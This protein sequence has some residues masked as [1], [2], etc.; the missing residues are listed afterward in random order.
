MYKQG[1]YFYAGIY[2]VYIRY[3]SAHADLDHL[4]T[5]VPCSVKT[6]HTDRLTSQALAGGV[7]SA[8]GLNALHRP[9]P[10]T[11]TVT[12]WTL[13]GPGRLGL[14]QDVLVIMISPGH[15]TLTTAGHGADRL[16]SGRTMPFTKRHP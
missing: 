5:H 3:I 4:Q 16:G 11:G 13:L 1:V 6:A 12:V 2:L 15:T 8:L 7:T 9:A 10:A 14:P